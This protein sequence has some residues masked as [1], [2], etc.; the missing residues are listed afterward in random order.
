MRTNSQPT[1]AYHLV[2]R[3]PA[4]RTGPLKFEVTWDN[5]SGRSWPGP[6]S[7]TCYQLSNTRQSWLHQ[8][9]IDEHPPL[10]DLNE[11]GPPPVLPH[12][13]Q[14]ALCGQ[15]QLGLAGVL[16][17]SKDFWEQLGAHGSVGPPR[18][19][20]WPTTAEGL[21]YGSTPGPHAAEPSR[22]AV[23]PGVVVLRR[24]RFMETSW[25]E[26]L[27]VYPAMFATTA[28]CAAPLA[29]G[30]HIRTQARRPHA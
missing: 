28:L 11:H 3:P 21:G 2:K 5:S 9:A 20:G 12:V 8:V 24:V 30:R 17:S 6:S 29:H 7:R 10:F 1:M 26:I 18:L 14:H 23:R 22:D 16:A 4:R 27:Y 15:R 25:T 19:G 13:A